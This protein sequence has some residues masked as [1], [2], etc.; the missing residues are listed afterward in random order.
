MVR[1]GKKS[2][3]LFGIFVLFTI[4]LVL[5]TNVISVN[6]LSL[7][8]N[9]ASAASTGSIVLN[10]VKTT[11]GTVSSSPYQITLSNVNAGTGTNRLLVV[12]VG[13]N[14]NVVT[15]V[16]F[17]GVPLTN[18]VSTFYNN[19]AEFWYLTNPS[20]TGNIVV[21]MA[22]ATSAVVGAY[23]FSGVDQTTPI[24]TSITNHNTAVS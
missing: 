18:K 11:S 24:P 9:T 1:H 6:P 3:S 12:G 21:T 22:G 19:D 13:A 8:P 15:S 2:Y 23:S 16:T 5:P 4:L 17:G 20:G 7:S 14:N 10:S